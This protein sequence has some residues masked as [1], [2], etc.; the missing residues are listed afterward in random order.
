MDIS[1]RLKRWT[2]DTLEMVKIV[3]G[4]AECKKLRFLTL[5]SVGYVTHNKTL[6]TLVVTM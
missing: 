6:I 2:N 4:V 1:M 5:L 3:S